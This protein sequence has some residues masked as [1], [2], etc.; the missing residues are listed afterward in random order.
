MTTTTHTTPGM[1]T[2][3]EHTPTLGVSL[4]KGTDPEHLHPTT[5]LSA[6]CDWCDRPS[7]WTVTYS[8][9]LLPDQACGVHGEAYFAHLMRLSPRH[10]NP[11][12]WYPL[13]GHRRG[14]RAN[15]LVTLASAFVIL[16]NE[17]GTAH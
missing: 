10:P 12:P 16:A 9:G 14:L 8:T 2:G 11:R 17:G 4:T 7:V 15:D 5:D 3:T 13:V 6:V 1:G